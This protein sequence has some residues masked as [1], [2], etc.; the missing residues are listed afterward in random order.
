MKAMGLPVEM[1]STKWS[2]TGNHWIE[3]I[4][5]REREERLGQEFKKGNRNFIMITVEFT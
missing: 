4:H 1:M 5:K 2:H 3:V